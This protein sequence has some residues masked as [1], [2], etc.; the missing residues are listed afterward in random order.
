[1]GNIPDPQN[2]PDNA[3]DAATVPAQIPE[4]LHNT[5]RDYVIMAGR[6]AASAIP[7]VGGAITELIGFIPQQRQDRVI[8]FLITLAQRMQALDRKFNT[9]N[10]MTVDLFES[11]V[12]QATRAIRPERNQ[13][14]VNLMKDCADVDA[15]Q[16]EV[17]K[18]ILH[19]LTEL[20]DKD[21]EVLK[22]HA[23]WSTTVA[24]ERDWPRARSLSAADRKLLDPKVKYEIESSH[25][26]LG[27]H[28]AILLRLDL[29]HPGQTRQYI[30]EVAGVPVIDTKQPMPGFEITTFG[31]L[32]LHRIFD[33][34]FD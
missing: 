21:I 34:Y 9:H 24:L 2:P 3:G 26:S 4:E 11:A 23:H 5:L 31:R 8:T 13:Y 15:T 20:T 33:E 10:L 16:Y 12:Q 25:V 6:A 17:D 32:L 1:M 22:A 27:I 7:I 30:H 28:R 18:K 14:L 19:V 29:I